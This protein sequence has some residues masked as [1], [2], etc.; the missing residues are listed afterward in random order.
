[1]DT[2]RWI[3]LI[4]G[5]FLIAAVYFTGRRKQPE[6]LYKAGGFADTDPAD[7]DAPQEVEESSGRDDE[8][9]HDD[10]ET[11]AVFDFEHLLADD[12]TRTPPTPRISGDDTRHSMLLEDE[13]V[14]LHLMVPSISV[15]SGSRLYDAL[16]E[17]G[18]TLEEDAVFHY[19]ESDSPLM[20]VNMFKPGTFPQDPDEFTSKGFSFILRLS[21]T[22]QPLDAFD[23]MVAL[24]YELKS[25]LNLQL[26]D[27]RRSSLTRQ[28]IAF[29]EEEIA[30]YQRRHGL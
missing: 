9:D 23:E 29:L 19:G 18:F 5:V 1:M 13:F 27:M 8:N 28:T 21:E 17:L 24:A 20:I 22:S 25:M 14:V 3:L 6:P 10:R 12:T 2:L 26:F 11:D 30:E 15:L 16:E 7:E 4:F